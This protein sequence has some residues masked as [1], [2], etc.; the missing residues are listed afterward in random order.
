MADY[1]DS[2]DLINVGAY[3][4][5]SN[6]KIDDAIAKREDIENFL[7][8]AVDEKSPIGETLA[9]LGEIAG[10]EIP[11]EEMTE[12]L[13]KMVLTPDD[14]EEFFED[15]VPAFSGELPSPEYS[16]AQVTAGA[17]SQAELPLIDL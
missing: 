12:Y 9:R 13:P 8:Q 15:Y 11:E 7:I 5:G 1:A 16:T 4:Q 6:P 17:E 10:I 14:E 3:K 2:E